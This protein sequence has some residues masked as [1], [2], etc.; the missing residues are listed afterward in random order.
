MSVTSTKILVKVG[1]SSKI[2]FRGAQ[3]FRAVTLDEMSKLSKLN[4]DASIA[5]IENIKQSDDGKLK[6][7]ISEFEAAN[8][9]NKVF[10]YVEDNDDVTCGV[11][12]EL[13]YEI[14]L[15]IKDLY[16]A[17]KLNCG[18]VVD[19]DL[20]LS[21]ELTNAGDD[22]DDIFDDSFGDALE[23][24]SKPVATLEVR[25]PDISNKD[26]LDDFDTSII[27]THKPKLDLGK[28]PSKEGHSDSNIEVVHVSN[29]EVES[30][31]AQANDE[32]TQLKGQIKAEFD[33]NKQLT[34]LVKAIESERDTFKKQLQL[35]SSTEVM[36]EPIPL[37]QYQELI[38]QIK[39]LK[40]E[41]NTG[42]VSNQQIEEM[43]KALDEAVAARDK[44]T[45]Q[46]ETY[47][48]RLM[49]SGT[50]LSNANEKLASSNS[51]L[52]ELRAKVASL[53][54][55][56]SESKL[57]DTT[58]N[59]K[60]ELAIALADLEKA[61][62][63]VMEA[64]REVN[65]IKV[66][67]ERVISEKITVE[68]ELKSEADARMFLI[69]VINNAVAE[70]Q[71]SENLLIARANELERSYAK[72]AL[73]E[74]ADIEAKERIAALEEQLDTLSESSALIESLKND[75][76]MLEDRVNTQQQTISQ[77]N[78]NI[79]AGVRSRAELEMKV[80]EADRRIELAVQKT[81]G[82]LEKTKLEVGEW[83]TKYELVNSQLTSKEEQ[84]NSMVQ[85]F[86]LNE[87]GA[88]S[89]IENSKAIE[90]MN[91]Q[92]KAQVL[93]LK[94]SLDN[95]L[96]ER[97][98]AKQTASALE[99][100]NKNMRA[101]MKSMSDL[102]GATGTGTR[103]AT[104]KPINYK[105]RGMVI[106][107]FGSG[108]FGIT[109][110]A[111]SIANKLSTQAKVLYIDLDLVAPKADAWFKT[112]PIVKNVPDV[113]PGSPKN[114][115]VGLLIDKPFQYVM[116]NI[117]SIISK[118]I[119]TKSGCVD[120]FSGL[121]AKFDAARIATANYEAL[122]NQCGNMYTYIIVDLGR[123]GS[124]DM[125][126]QIIKAF[127]DIAYKS[128]MVTTS[129]KFEIRTFRMKLNDAHINM[130]KACWLVNMCTTTRFD[131]RSK[132]AVAPAVYSMMPFS[133]ELYGKQFNFMNDQLTRDKLSLFMET[134][135]ARR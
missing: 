114:T 13:A 112:N 57:L 69:D 87:A 134:V 129:D 19:T 55:Q 45:K 16:T 108:S 116:Q 20:E 59:I 51:E 88:S 48:E 127:T 121:Y 91:N 9:N 132:A 2:K 35:Y 36:E 11:A 109:T 47:K 100:S 14:Y 68:D 135:L 81:Q 130:A 106:P 126:D 29:T 101:S 53:E 104:V 40:S 60:S 7:F 93:T 3:A 26:D 66:E 128:V 75:N 120:Y 115:G 52:V 21:A 34:I 117:H 122:L 63:D 30:K 64:N 111:M 94:Q 4:P 133:P 32:I 89:M 76:K 96:K 79:S 44:A 50:R 95:A 67:Y 102:M 58:E 124:S 6:K 46:V 49:E 105:A 61:R 85:S 131:D 1:K 65:R 39:Q 70:S 103:A 25:L 73:F 83:K 86:G 113:E 8:E 15:S 71:E 119:Q 28:A 82:E 38:E 12:D 27:G 62:A 54:E 84:Y 78:R 123:L 99:E 56:V 23:A 43:Q 37:T 118:P 24:I 80:R 92:L 17:I 90:S 77:L 18:I 107:V 72:I 5:I 125:N 42:I 41:S 22:S 110:T 31:L 10:F 97:D 33:R 74:K 98:N